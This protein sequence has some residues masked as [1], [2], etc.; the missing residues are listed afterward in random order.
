[1]KKILSAPSPDVARETW[2]MV[3]TLIVALLICTF[4]PWVSLA[5]HN[6]F[7]GATP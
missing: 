4:S 2:A 1:M 5:L 7:L 6:L 3:M